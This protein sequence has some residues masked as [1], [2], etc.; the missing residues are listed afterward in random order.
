MTENEFYENWHK[1]CLKDGVLTIPE[2]IN[3]LDYYALCKGD[4]EKIRKVVLPLSGIHILNGVFEDCVNLEELENF[5]PKFHYDEYI[6]D[7]ETGENIHFVEDHPC[8]VFP[9]AFQGCFKLY[10][11]KQRTEEDGTVWL[12]MD[13]KSFYIGIPKSTHPFYDEMCTFITE[14]YLKSGIAEKTAFSFHEKITRYG[15]EYEYLF[16]N[17]ALYNKTNGTWILYLSQYSD[18]RLVIPEWV[19]EYVVHY[20]PQTSIDYVYLV[21]KSICF[22]GATDLKTVLSWIGKSE[23]ENIEFSSEHTVVKSLALCN[24]KNLQYAKFGNPDC[25][26]E[27]YSFARCDKLTS[28]VGLKGYTIQNGAIFHQGRINSVLSNEVCYPEGSEWLDDCLVSH[29]IYLPKSI[30]HIETNPNFKEDC[31]DDWMPTYL[32]AKTIVVP[33]GYKDYYLNL[34]WEN[35]QAYEGWFGDVTKDI[36]KEKIIET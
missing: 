33:A 17:G 20:A 12:D 14:K 23:L 21:I 36:L 25:T 11:E 24:F 8:E 18:K 28:L 6:V 30:K 1:D 22:L 9:T 26:L 10:P 35:L 5:P 16:E 32:Y 7:E 31:N 2:E 15:V 34:F 27:R 4:C 29:T 13:G 19:K 3:T